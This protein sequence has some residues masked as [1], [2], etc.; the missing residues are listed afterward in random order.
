MPVAVLIVPEPQLE[1]RVHRFVLRH[2]RCPKPPALDTDG[3]EAPTER[4][5]LGLERE[6]PLDL[7]PLVELVG[8][9]TVGFNG[10]QLHGHIEGVRGAPDALEI[11]PRL[12]LGV[13]LEAPLRYFFPNGRQISILGVEFPLGVDAL[14]LCLEHFDHIVDRFHQVKQVEQGA[15]NLRVGSPERIRPAVAVIVGT[16]GETERQVQLPRLDLAPCPRVGLEERDRLL[17]D[18][19]E[20]KLVVDGGQRH[21]ELAHQPPLGI[22]VDDPSSEHCN[23]QV[24]LMHDVHLHRPAMVPPRREE[25]VD[26]LGD[27]SFHH[28]NVPVVD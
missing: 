3:D 20:G 1:K 7:H 23:V 12:Q 16:L 11:L 19:S 17:H 24:A 5:A 14:L 21:L 4:F 9:G 18:W 25:Y 22:L 8:V 6:R 13:L 26:H 28:V 15:A 10:H 2:P 27:N